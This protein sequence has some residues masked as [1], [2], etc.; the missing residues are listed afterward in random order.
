MR[1]T[2]TR[3]GSM[4]LQVRMHIWTASLSVATTQGMRAEVRTVEVM[5]L[6]Y[7]ISGSIL[8]K[9]RLVIT[10]ARPTPRALPWLAALRSR[11]QVR[12]TFTPP[13]A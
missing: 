11:K 4:P 8:S 1:I 10:L 5:Q 12:W 13:W 2:R 7:I 6:G 3:A 9:N